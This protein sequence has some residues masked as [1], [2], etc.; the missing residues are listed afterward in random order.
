MEKTL[1]IDNREVTFKSTAATPLRYKAQFG[2]DYFADIL[3]MNA[4][5]E[6]NLESD[7]IDYEKLKYLDFETFYNLLW[8]MAKTKDS[9]VPDPITWLDTFDEFPLM[10]ILPEIQEL[11]MKNLGE[12]KKK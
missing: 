10:E 3:K 9:S 8:V 11:I 7:K 5:T 6:V 2:R 1:T 12:V 4:L